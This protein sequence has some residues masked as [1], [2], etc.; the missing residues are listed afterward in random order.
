MR[1]SSA[2][3]V[4][5][6]AGCSAPSPYTQTV[7]GTIYR[8][9]L[10]VTGIPVLFVLSPSAEARPCS[11]VV[12]KAVTNQ[13]GQFSLSTQYVPNQRENYAV[14]VQ[15][16]A[17]CAQLEGQWLPIWEFTT[18]PAMRNIILRCVQN[19]MGKVSCEG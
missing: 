16:H 19:E 4:L 6:L 10:P 7:A 8:D 12:A 9:S 3:I 18:G 13:N 15:H 11:P 2:L 5:L 14:L 1:V 17:V